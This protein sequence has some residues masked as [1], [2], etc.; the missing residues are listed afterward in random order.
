[1]QRRRHI[2]RLFVAYSVVVLISTFGV[3]WVT[4]STFMATGGGVRPWVVAHLLALVISS[5]AIGVGAWYAYHASRHVER[6]RLGA[7]RFARGDLGHQVPI[8]ESEELGGVADALNRMASQLSDKLKTI[9]QQNNEQQAVLSSM[10]EGVIAI[11]T[12]GVILSLNGAAADL[13]GVDPGRALGMRLQNLLR[14]TQL[15]TFVEKAVTST[16]RTQS[17]IVLQRNS[18]DLFL[19]ISGS[20]LRDAND[21]AIGAL[22]VFNDVTRLRRLE[23][24]RR[25]FVANVSH[26]LRT[27]ITSIKG[28]IETLRDGA[29]SD[30]QR[31]EEFLSIV[32][33]QADRLNAIIEDLLR[34]SRIE[35][36]QERGVIELAPARLRKVLQSAATDCQN[37]ADQRGVNIVVDCPE[38][39]MPHI[40][41]PLIEQA[42]VNLIDNAIKYSDANN[43]VEITGMLVDSDVQIRVRDYGTGIAS[44][45]LTRLFERFYRVDKARSRKQGGTGLGLAI[46]KHIAQAHRGKVWVESELG[47]GTTFYIQLPRMQQGAKPQQP[48]PTPS[49]VVAPA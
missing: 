32:A 41:A 13:I 2:W 6:L 16:R 42:V 36:D 19:Q 35:Q 48:V 43:A 18:E 17:D 38:E 37:A 44:E 15:Q 24:V 5:L 33:R 10:T 46:V 23:N 20:V 12:D 3:T 28:F 14:N 45:H 30:P 31:T 22:V 29:A 21:H 34:L 26:E 7:E 25:D 39:L 27:P 40:N 11:D 4:G 8:H 49:P 1:M 9:T 47:E